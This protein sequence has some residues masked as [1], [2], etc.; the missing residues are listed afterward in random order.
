MKST[1]DNSRVWADSSQRAFNPH[2][3]FEVTLPGGCQLRFF[4]GRCLLLVKIVSL[5]IELVQMNGQNKAEAL[6]FC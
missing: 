6:I 2:S 1:G 4:L 5:S 3:L